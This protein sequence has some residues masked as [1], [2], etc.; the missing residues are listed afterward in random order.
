MECLHGEI[1]DFPNVHICNLYPQ[2]QRSTGN[3]H[4]AKYSGLDFKIPPFAADPRDTAAEMVKLAKNPKTHTF[5][6]AASF[7]LKNIYG[8]F[9]KTIINTASAGMRLLMKT[10]DGPETNGNVMV[11]SSV[12]H[13]IYG[14]TILPVPSRKT[15]RLALAATLGTAAYFLFKISKGKK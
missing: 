3:S 2:I 8:L 15:K 13:R 7:L 11:P 4:S 9:P 14:E 5:P 6:D 10:V 12:P 1:S